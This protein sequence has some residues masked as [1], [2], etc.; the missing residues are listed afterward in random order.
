MGHGRA[1]AC[2]GLRR[3]VFRDGEEAGTAGRPGSAGGVAAESED[4]AL[5]QMARAGWQAAR[6]QPKASRKAGC[7]GP[8]A[9]SSAREEGPP[10]T[11][12]PSPRGPPRS[13][14]AAPETLAIGPR[15]RENRRITEGFLSLSTKTSP[16]N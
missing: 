13:P 5:R 16:D 11:A 2:G 1:H 15:G 12:A 7:T 9:C 4:E 3:T 10:A 6:P 8:A 14:N